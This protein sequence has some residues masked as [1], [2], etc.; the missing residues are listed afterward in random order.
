MGRYCGVLSIH[1]S[2]CFFIILYWCF[3]SAA[4]N[5]R[6]RSRNCG[7]LVTWFCYQLIA[8]PG[9]KTAAVSWPHPYDVTVPYLLTVDWLIIIWK[10]TLPIMS[11]LLKLFNFMWKCYGIFWVYACEVLSHSWN[12]TLLCRLS[13]G[14]HT[15]SP[16]PVW[17]R[18]PGP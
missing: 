2:V 9:N 15:V 5:I 3:Q 6:V 18:I 11:K 16:A 14:C 1:W 8:K 13:M 10:W 17:V 4:Q 7:C 12:S